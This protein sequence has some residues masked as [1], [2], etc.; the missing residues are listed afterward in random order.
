MAANRSTCP[1]AGTYGDGPVVYQAA[2]PV[3]RFDDEAGA[4]YAVIGSWYIT[5]QGAA[6]IGVRE[7]D[8][9]ITGNLSRFVPHYFD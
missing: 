2:A 3:P 9:P 1:T 8:S 4:R 6:G 7:S 5:D